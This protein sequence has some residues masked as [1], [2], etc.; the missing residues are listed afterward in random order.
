[1]RADVFEA[2]YRNTGSETRFVRFRRVH[3][4]GIAQYE[5]YPYT[6]P[7]GDTRENV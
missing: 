6:T 4:M 2:V 5:A 7:L 3:D 1:M